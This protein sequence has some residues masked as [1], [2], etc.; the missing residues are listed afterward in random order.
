MT[1]TDFY[2][3]RNGERIAEVSTSTNYLDSAGSAG[4]RYAVAPV[5]DGCEGARCGGSEGLG[6]GISGLPLKRPEGSVTS[7][8]KAMCTM[9]MI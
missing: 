9:P 5:R 4:D 6:E 1:G 2:V 8:G 3:Y 7:Q